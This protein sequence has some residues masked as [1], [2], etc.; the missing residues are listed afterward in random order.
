MDNY[1]DDIRNFDNDPRSPFY[2]EPICRECGMEEI[3]CICNDRCDECG[4]LRNRVVDE[5]TCNK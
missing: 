5:C 2:V 1:P 4:E 3:D